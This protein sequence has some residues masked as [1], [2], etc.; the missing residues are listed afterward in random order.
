MDPVNGTF[1]MS[2]GVDVCSRTGCAN[3]KSKSMRICF[4]TQGSKVRVYA[5]EPNPSADGAEIY[6]D[7]DM[8]NKCETINKFEE[9]KL[10]GVW[11]LNIFLEI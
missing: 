5:V 11:E 4:A 9:N 10:Y 7:K 8:R 3:D 1:T 6:V 2:S